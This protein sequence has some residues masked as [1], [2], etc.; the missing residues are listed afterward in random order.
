M[1]TNRNVALLVLCMVVAGPAF[2][3]SG[4]EK[5]QVAPPA[6]SDSYGEDEKGRKLRI[7]HREIVGSNF[8]IAGVDLASKKEEMEAAFGEDVLSQAARV[9]GKVTTVG[10]GD[11]AY[12]NEEACYRS[13]EQN[14]STYLI[15]GRGEVESSFTL[16]SDSSAW[17]WKT[18]CKRSPR[19][20]R[21]L[22][23]SSGLHLGQTQEQV[24]A[25]LGLPTRRSRNVQYGR[26]D[27]IYD[28]E[29]RKR[30]DPQE[31]A[32]WL[33]KELQQHPDASQIEFH[34]TYDFYELV[35]Y[36]HAKFFNN[37]LINLTVS[38]SAQY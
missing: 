35:V 28:L 8:Q 26:D 30:T 27:L 29:A 3:L 17:K 31:L 14:D 37:A 25:I 2:R 5:P 12:S 9:L 22:A 34:E 20:T 4:Q 36:I 6:K 32:L 23:T 13:A 18:P 19:V 24:I 15:F 11:G 33:K 1:Q 10:S 7:Q 38:W 21:S 16:S